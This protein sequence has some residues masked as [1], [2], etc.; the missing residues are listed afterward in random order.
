MAS[1]QQLPPQIK[2]VELARRE[3][4]RPVVRYQV[5][6]D[7]GEVDGKRKR[8]RKRYA[9]EKEARDALDEI[10]GDVTK[11]TYVHPTTLTVDKACEDWL[12][13]R[14]KLKATS[15]EGYAWIL[16]PVRAELGHIPCR[17]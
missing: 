1:R 8:V 6:V 17:S 4:G 11:G 13:S 9:T 15:A 14:H 2:R 10:R 12:V 5:T 3:S 7:V 16:T